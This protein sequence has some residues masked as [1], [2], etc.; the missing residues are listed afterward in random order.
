MLGEI[1]VVSSGLRWDDLL[2]Q[3]VYV[4]FETLGFTRGM[5]YAPLFDMASVANS[6]GWTC[7]SGFPKD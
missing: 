1:C 3:E 2:G 6:A 4:H 5:A 7:G